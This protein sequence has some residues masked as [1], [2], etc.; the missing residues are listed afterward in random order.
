M[1]YVGKKLCMDKTLKPGTRN[2]E[3][4]QTCWRS[5]SNIALVKYWGKKPVQVPANPSI[6]MTLKK[7]L[8][9]MSLECREK[10]NDDLIS[11]EF[12][13]E[14]APQEKFGQK[15]GS[16][17]DSIS[18]AYPVLKKFH[19]KINSRN[20]FPHSTGIASSASSMS[21]LGLC[22]A[23]FF[24]QTGILPHDES[25]F[26]QEASKLARLASGS[27]C[28]SVY[29]GY[30]IWGRTSEIQGSSDEYGIPVPFRVAET[31]LDIR[32]AILVVSSKEKNV[33]SRAGHSLMEHHPYASNRFEIAG[34]NLLAIS[35]AIRKGDF[36]EFVRI[37][38]WEALG[39]HALMMTSNPSYIL[40]EPNTIHIVN[41]VKRFR[42]ETGIPVCFTLDAGP[43]VHLLYPGSEAGKVLEWIRSELVRFCENGKWI[44]DGT[45]S[46]PVKI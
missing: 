38:E 31:F 43:N 1:S 46:G 35:E 34:K 22:L 39:L 28:R 15:I 45:G 29:G 3:S 13:F 20:S 12:S 2:L 4:F 32:D 25:L 40:F 11:L 26:F 14:G 33:S 8:T 36:E 16:F 37:T 17:L 10:E 30:V 9:E 42:K 19:F 6:S 44:D 5:P 21:A 7:A 23:D 18:P 27:A 24:T 41:E